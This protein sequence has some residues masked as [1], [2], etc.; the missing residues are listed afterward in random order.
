MKFDEEQKVMVLSCSLP[1]Q[2]T[3]FVNSLIYGRETLTL[4]DVKTDLLSEELRDQIKGLGL[5]HDSGESD[6]S[7]NLFV[8]RGRTEKQEF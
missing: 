5:G 6:S 4:N 8:K 1:E 7:S 3:I 2:F